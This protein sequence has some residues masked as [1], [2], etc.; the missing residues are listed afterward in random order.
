[1]IISKATQGVIPAWKGLAL[2]NLLDCVQD[3]ATGNSIDRSRV[4]A[5]TTM[6][7][8]SYSA[9]H[10]RTL[11]FERNEEFVTEKLDQK[12]IYDYMR[13]RIK[14]SPTDLSNQDTLDLLYEASI[15]VGESHIMT[16]KGQK[17]W[18]SPSTFLTDTIV[19]LTQI[20]TV[21]SNISLLWFNIPTR[22]S[23]VL[24]IRT[25]AFFLCFLPPLA[26]FFQ[27]AHPSMTKE[28]EALL[29][30][31]WMLNWIASDE[32][33]KQEVYLFDWGNW[34]LK[35]WEVAKAKTDDYYKRTYSRNTALPF[36]AAQECIQL[37]Q[38]A[39][40][41]LS[42]YSKSISVSSLTLYQNAASALIRAFQDFKN[43]LLNVLEACFLSAA[44]EECHRM[45]EERDQKR[46][47]LLTYAP[48]VDEKGRKGMR[49]EAK[50]LSFTYPGADKP[51][52]KN[53]N[54]TIE[55]G[56]TLALVGFNGGGKTTL[57]KVMMGLFEY[58]GELLIDGIEAK[59]YNPA[60]LFARTTAC[61]QD[62]QKYNMTVRENI[63]VGKWSS[64]YEDSELEAALAKGGAS[65][66]MG[67]AGSLDGLLCPYGVPQAAKARP[68]DDDKTALS[69]GQWQR[70]AL[71]RAFVRTNDASLVVFDEPS[72]A[73]DAK[74]EHELFER[75]H[76]LSLSESGE[77]ARTTIYISH[78]F[79]TVRKA[80]KIAV[81]EGG[82]ISE[83]GNHESLMKL[84]GRYA[85][86]FKLQ[87]DAFA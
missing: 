39:F 84:G 15:I 37:S 78:R 65:D 34:V 1:M 20:V 35:E 62:F 11:I 22:S 28:E 83:I 45:V 2:A 21:I 9:A 47:G 36:T 26:E 56:E 75:I 63:A 38:Y 53:I 50:N 46:A 64:L 79:S 81:I 69:G 25:T 17:R 58:E 5:A 61:F 85:E 3:A 41:A 32:S 44:L 33:Y 31:Q 67:A 86:F 77:R 68:E 14:L 57:V 42:A 82:T 66:V 71:A 30:R 16:A 8:L 10:L 59:S 4:I 19:I 49:I 27:P 13:M 18:L 7:L 54:L 29:S 74:A 73:L 48:A 60:S 55:P 52:L 12:I 80:D 76:S 43:A 87:A 72:S 40:L 23:D 51:S 70:M 24:I 6:A